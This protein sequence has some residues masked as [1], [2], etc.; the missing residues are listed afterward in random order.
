LQLLRRNCS[1]RIEAPASYGRKLKWP[2]KTGRIR[3]RTAKPNSKDDK[4]QMS[5]YD[6]TEGARLLLTQQ[7]KAHWNRWG[8]FLS[9]RAWGTVREDYSA[10]GDAWSYFPHDHARSR[11]YRWNEDGIAGISDR[12]QFLCFAVALWNGRDPFLKERLFGLTGIEGNH[13]EDVKEYYFYLDNTPTHSYMKYLYKYPQGEYPY[14]LL[15]E[16]NRRRSKQ[17]TEFELVDTGIFDESRYFDVLVEYA[18]AQAEDLLIR[19]TV[20]NRGPDTAPIHVLPTLWFRNTW[21]WGRDD[22]RPSIAM[23]PG[24]QPKQSK[25]SAL[26]TTQHWQLGQ[27]ALY[28]SGADELLFTEN[29]TNYSRL[30]GVTSPASHC[31]DAFNECVVEG[32]LES[33]NPAATGSKTAAHYTRT[34]GSGETVTFDLRLASVVDGRLLRAPFSE[35]DSLLRRRRKEADEFYSVV[36]PPTLSADAKLVA[37]Q[38][39]AGMLWSK[40]YYHY[41]VTDW[42]EGDP[43]QP[44][45]PP[46]RLAGRNHDWPHLFARDVISMPDKWEFPWFASWDLG[47]HC[48]ALAHI[49]PHFAKEQILLMLREWYMHPN[50]QIPAYEWDFNGVNPPVLSLAARFVFEVEQQHTGVA[51][52][53]FI[54]RVFQKMLLNFTWWVN[55]KDA[56]GKNIF[57]GGFLGM[58]NIGVFDR[59]KLPPGYLLGQA[60]GTSWMAAFAKNMFGT[61]L[62]LAER[63]PIY[64]DLASKFWE[65]YIYI[66]NSMNS[67]RDSNKSLWDEEDGFFYDHLISRQHEPIP[68]RARTMVGFVPMF[69]ANTVPAD[70]FDRYPDFQRRRQWFI[71]HR[72]DL[73]E[74]LGAM[75]VPGANKNLMLGLVRTD[76]LRRMLRYMLDENEFFSPY[77]VRSV[78]RYHKDHPLILNLAGQESRLDY[79]VGESMTDLFGGNSNWRGPIW[80]PVNFLILLALKQYHLYYG[81]E[82]KVE[83]PTGSGKMKNLDQVAEELAQ[84]LGSIFLRDK[85]GNRPVFGSNAMFNTDPHWRD[86]IPFHEYFHGDTGRG[87]GASHQTGW[88]GLIAQILIDL[89]EHNTENNPSQ[90]ED[91]P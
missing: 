2:I 58:D 39:F 56:L 80:L 36:L 54:E 32:K 30:Y 81:N 67:L 87:C 91:L 25:V 8:P 84:R 42:L 37:R 72:P 83:C 71:E 33:V 86:L 22:R 59:D 70:A 13:G 73:L 7:K 9:E 65:H 74:S 66:A 90:D 1:A 15:R 44:V 79:E 64:E 38:A 3:L 46:E 40:Q 18:K 88:T 31:K 41:V 5:I 17:E 47:F 63:N 76:Q 34:V 60:D 24:G 4:F 29:E 16:E 6:T 82:F 35:F 10:N 57:Q 52:Y 55:R 69:G 48:A 68:I 11:A 26:I 12:H 27:Y 50:G 89:G 75:V 49:D 28:C 21:R 77:G 23:G 19:I 85:D 62:L 45:P 78:S 43:P 53:A 14:D 51:D 20:S 61:A